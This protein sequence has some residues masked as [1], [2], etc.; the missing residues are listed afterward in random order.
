VR[1]GRAARA[2]GNLGF[3]AV[4]QGQYGQAA[5]DLGESLALCREIGD[6][7]GEARALANLGE[8]ALRQD[9]YQE[10]ARHLYEALAL[11]REVGDRPSEADTLASL[12][13]ISAPEAEQV[14]AELAGDAAW[15]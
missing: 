7:G 12:G 10:A 2:L 9:R 8:V 11:L 6:R 13:V 1:G 3:A 4:R 14:H 15:V 5:R